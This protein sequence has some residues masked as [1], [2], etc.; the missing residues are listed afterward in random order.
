MNEEI[1]IMLAHVRELVAPTTLARLE[2]R[3]ANWRQAVRERANVKA[4]PLP[5][6]IMRSGGIPSPLNSRYFVLKK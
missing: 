6:L 4:G 1:A 2:Q 3:V 5:S